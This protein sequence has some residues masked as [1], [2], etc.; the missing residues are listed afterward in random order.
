[1]KNIIHILFPGID[2]PENRL[3][4]GYQLVINLA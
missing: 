1:M 3:P 2:N 4:L